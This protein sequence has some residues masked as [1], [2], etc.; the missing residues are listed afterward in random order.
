MY[1]EIHLR[2]VEKP[3]EKD[4]Q[5]DVEWM[6]NSFGFTTGRDTEQLTPR[7]V[8]ELLRN[9]AKEH[10]ASSEVLA[11]QLHVTPARVNY[12]IRNLMEAGFVY[13]NKRLIFLRG[14]S[15][16]TAVQELRKDANR[17]FDELE[18]VAEEIDGQLGLRN[19][20]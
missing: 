11:H 4:I 7:T 12:H 19:R 17:I 5:E 15:V 16:K 9:V 1:Q 20:T 14:S 6:C 18:I 2:T 3:A 10:A 13:R 8:L